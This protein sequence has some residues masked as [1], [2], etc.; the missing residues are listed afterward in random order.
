MY[1]QSNVISNMKPRREFLLGVVSA[2]TILSG[3]TETS[4]TSQAQ[5]SQR[6]LS[7]DASSARSGATEAGTPTDTETGGKTE[8]PPEET[9]TDSPAAERTPD[10]GQ[11]PTQGPGWYVRP[12]HP[13]ET[14]PSALRCESQDEPRKLGPQDPVRWGNTPD[15]TWALRVESTEYQR[16]DT[17]RVRLH[18][19]SE[20]R[21]RRGSDGA[22][23]LQMY[24]QN[25]WESIDI[26]LEGNDLF[27]D[28]RVTADVER[29][30]QPGGVQQWRFPVTESGL[31]GRV[32]PDL[33]PGRYRVVYT[34]IDV[35]LA[36]SFDFT[37]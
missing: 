1:K 17:L 35:D 37:T 24:T 26:Q 6:S 2:G 36:V 33:Q 34:G 19:T 4:G 7:P 30:Q 32:C 12:G 16:G 31:P 28:S 27:G 11:H 8:A 10:W 20:T 15:D 9:P 23:F 13:P 5:S 22:I 14:V 3:C 25:G 18:N 29:F 21:Q